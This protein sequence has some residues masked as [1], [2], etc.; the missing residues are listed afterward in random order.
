MAAWA[1]RRL[2]LP[3]PESLWLPE[4]LMATAGRHQGSTWCP[5]GRGELVLPTLQ[6][7]PAGKGGTE[8]VIHT[9]GVV[10]Q[11]QANSA[12]GVAQAGRPRSQKGQNR[13]RPA[14]GVSTS[15]RP[16][17]HLP[18]IPPLHAQRLW[19]GWEAPPVLQSHSG[20]CRLLQQ[21][22]IG[23]SSILHS[24]GTSSSSP[25]QAPTNLNCRKL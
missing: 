24:P 5:R 9:Q 16:P 6:T 20:T 17:A 19:P 25:C 22:K 13:H 14:H 15:I 23:T 2:R 4:Q 8:G 12:A 21:S 1:Q 7:P 3:M 10:A 11:G 18:F